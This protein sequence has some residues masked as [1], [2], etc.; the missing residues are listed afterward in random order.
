MDLKD[1]VELVGSPFYTDD[2]IKYLDAKIS[3]HRHR[4][5]QV[6]PEAKLLRKHHFLE[7]YLQL[8]KAFEPL[9]AL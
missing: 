1:I 6:F 2:T 9:V 5:M 4:Y 3:K 7:H 8:I